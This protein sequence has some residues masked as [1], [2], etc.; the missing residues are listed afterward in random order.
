MNAGNRDCGSR[1]AFS[2]QTMNR[3]ARLRS[4]FRTGPGGRAAYSNNS[5]QESNFIPGIELSLP[6]NRNPMLC[7]VQFRGI[8]LPMNSA[9]QCLEMSTA[10]RHERRARFNPGQ[11]NQ[12]AKCSVVRRQTKFGSRRT[13]VER[14]GQNPA[15]ISSNSLIIASRM[16]WLIGTCARTGTPTSPSPTSSKAATPNASMAA[17]LPWP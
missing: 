11:P 15:L 12:C 3:H 8:R 16:S 6:N 10:G 13:Q 17:W 5:N 1:Q 4:I 9:E 14:T 7:A 2:R